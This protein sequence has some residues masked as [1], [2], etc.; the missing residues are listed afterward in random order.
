MVVSG[1]T[2]YNAFEGQ[3]FPS[4]D[5]TRTERELAFGKNSTE[6]TAQWKRCRLWSGLL[7]AD[8]W[9]KI[10]PARPLSDLERT[11]L[12]VLLAEPFP[13]SE[14]LRHQAQL[15][16][17][18]AECT[19]GCGSIALIVDR[20]QAIHAE[21]SERIPVEGRSSGPADGGTSVEVL[22]HVVDGFINEL[23]VVPYTNS[24]RFPDPLTLTVWRKGFQAE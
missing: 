9:R 24:V 8:A 13:G 1:D 19:C 14:A 11:T 5:C 23:E 3:L 2:N 7:A 16:R 6:T 18:N 4:S 22:L 15:A 12:A 17:V 20:D 21:V 10:E